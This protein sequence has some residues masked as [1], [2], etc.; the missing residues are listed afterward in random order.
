MNSR[1]LIDDRLYIDPELVQFYDL[2]NGGREDFDY[3]VK[4]AGKARSAL[5]LGCGT[6]ELA[7]ALAD[8]RS[9]V[10]VD[11]AHAML[12]V[13]RKRP[14][15][16]KVEWVQADA[17]NVRLGRRFDLIVLSGHA[18]QVFLTAEDQRAVLATIAS[19]LTPEGRFIFD[20]RSPATEEWREWVP[21]QSIRHVTHP[22][23]GLAKAWNDVSRD[24]ATGIVTYES[25]Y[26][27][28]GTGMQFQAESK[29]AFPEKDALAEMID[30]A[31]LSVEEWLGNWQ[32]DPWTPS[33][34]EIIPVGRLRRSVD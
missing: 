18:F 31:G 10:G 12:E 32:G 6:G 9:V 27:V 16:K 1:D 30:D 8:G 5:D 14:G 2:E 4:F 25:H 11:P 19:H 28:L 13:A 22:E 29:I 23:Y 17:R 24:D 33:S 34:P 7:T 20:T 15:G 21:E 3:C 26:Q